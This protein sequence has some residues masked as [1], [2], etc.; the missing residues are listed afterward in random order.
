MRRM[1]SD[2]KRK[3]HPCRTTPRFEPLSYARGLRLLAMALAAPAMA[4]RPDPGTE[5]QGRP[6]AG[7][8]NSMEYRG[9]SL[10]PATHG[11]GSSNS[12]V[13][14]EEAQHR[15]AGAGPAPV[16]QIRRVEDTGFEFL[17]VGGGFLVGATF[18]GAERW[19][20]PL[21]PLP[22]RATGGRLKR[23]NT[24]T[25]EMASDLHVRRSD[26][27]SLVVCEPGS[28]CARC[29]KTDRDAAHTLAK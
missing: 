20:P 29:A 4:Y 23:R 10:G 13:H 6:D 2:Q 24:V 7:P 14:P 27:I 9:G 22:R 26:A 16:V 21:P 5:P 28:M 18:V 3:A 11:Q 8:A 25:K 19:P 12:A 17:Q 15:A 1:R